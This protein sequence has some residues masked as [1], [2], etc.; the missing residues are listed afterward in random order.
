MGDQA[1]ATVI[2][3]A[4]SEVE[5]NS[6]KDLLPLA[7]SQMRRRQSPRRKHPFRA[8]KP[9][10]TRKAAWEHSTIGYLPNTRAAGLDYAA[11][12]TPSI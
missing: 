2:F 9:R 3:S 12:A 5:R 8:A 1:P 7:W 11:V 4:A 6:T 10:E